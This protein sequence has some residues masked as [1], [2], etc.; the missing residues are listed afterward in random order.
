MSNQSA[1]ACNISRRSFVLGAAAAAVTMSV[2]GNAVE[3]AFAEGEVDT[4]KPIEKRH[5]FC[6]M[7]NQVPF[8]GLTAYVQDEHVVRIESRQP[9]ATGPLCA[10]GLASIQELYDPER[11]LYPM[12]RTNEKGVAADWEQISWDDAYQE[13]AAQ[14]N[15]VKA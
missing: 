8:C 9:F 6:D 12:R 5:T 14:L 1:G 3:F 13:I 2:S 10:K 15:R 11:L 4:S 7:C